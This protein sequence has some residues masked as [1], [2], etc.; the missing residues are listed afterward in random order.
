MTISNAMEELVEKVRE[1]GIGEYFD[2]MDYDKIIEMGLYYYRKHI[3]EHIDEI[4]DDME[5]DSE[6]VE[7]SGDYTKCS[8][9]PKMITWEEFGKNNGQCLECSPIEKD[10]PLDL[11]DSDWMGDMGA[12]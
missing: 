1:L 2:G 4:M 7:N 8:T 10:E 6:S 11:E 9:C 5:I 3:E 12:V